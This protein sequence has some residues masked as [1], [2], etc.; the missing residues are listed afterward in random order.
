MTAVRRKWRP[1][2]PSRSSMRSEMVRHHPSRDQSFPVAPIQDLRAL[3][4]P[5]RFPRFLLRFDED[6]QQQVLR[7]GAIRRKSRTS[8]GS[9]RRNR[10]RDSSTGSATLYSRLPRPRDS[11][12]GCTDR[13]EG[14]SAR[15]CWP[16][17][18][19]RSLPARSPAASTPTPR[20][21]T[22]ASHGAR[23]PRIGRSLVLGSWHT[24]SSRVGAHKP[25][26]E[27]NHEEWG[28]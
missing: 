2:E 17:S 23:F 6:H 25:R 18:A 13:G 24:V 1:P 12:P 21:A 7:C 11:T 20:S 15:D 3:S 14:A 8:V 19:G 4:R 28:V 22:R 5:D 9:R 10:A 26:I 16:K 27:P